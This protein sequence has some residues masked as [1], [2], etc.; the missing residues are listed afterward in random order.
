[1]IDISL[2][3]FRLFGVAQFSAQKSESGYLYLTI[4]DSADVDPSVGQVRFQLRDADI[5]QLNRA[6]AAWNRE[7]GCE[8]K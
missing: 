4:S 2:S 3:V 8:D 1:M 7:M 6:V 5:D